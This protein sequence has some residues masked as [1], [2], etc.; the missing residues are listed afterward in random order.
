M[1][2]YHEYLRLGPRGRGER[3]AA[4]VEAVLVY[5]IACMIVSLHYVV[6]LYV[7]VYHII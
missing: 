3:V 2:Y 6:I 5:T 4:R 7:I 1:L